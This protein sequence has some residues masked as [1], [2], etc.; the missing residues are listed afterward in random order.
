MGVH[1]PFVIAIAVAWIAIA[2]G[3]FL[4]FFDR[5][6]TDDYAGWIIVLVVVQAPAFASLISAKIDEPFGIGRAL[7]FSIPASLAI[8]FAIFFL[9][10]V[11]AKLIWPPAFLEFRPLILAGA[12]TIVVFVAS[13]VR[14]TRMLLRRAHPNAVRQILLAVAI[15]G[16]IGV[17][18][19]ATDYRALRGDLG[20]W[21]VVAIPLLWPLPL[22]VLARRPQRLPEARLR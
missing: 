6:D 10:V 9:V 5:R 17:V 20:I 12:V 7:A 14:A 1:R 15:A 19:V 18:A 21:L 2:A 3:L 11:L 8:A 13:L 4:Y 22:A 16:S